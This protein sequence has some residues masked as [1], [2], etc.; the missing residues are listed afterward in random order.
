[1]PALRALNEHGIEKFRKYLS[2]IRAGNEIP[3]QPAFLYDDLLTLSL[4]HI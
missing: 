3:L 4:I 1:M 2:S